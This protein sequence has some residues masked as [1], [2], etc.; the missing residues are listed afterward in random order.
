MTYSTSD[1]EQSAKNQNLAQGSFDLVVALF[2]TSPD[3]ICDPEPTLTHIRHT[4]RPGGYLVMLILPDGLATRG[5]ADAFNGGVEDWDN[6]LRKTGFSGLDT[7]TATATHQSQPGA[8][9][10]ATLLATQAED[11]RVSFLRE[12]LPAAK[13][14]LSLESLTILGEDR[15][16]DVSQKLGRSVGA[17]YTKVQIVTSLSG[18]PDIPSGGTVVCFL[19]LQPAGSEGGA[20]T[21]PVLGIVQT[22][23]RRAHNILW[24]TSGARSGANPHGNMIK[25]LLRSVALEMPDIRTQFLDFATSDDV[26]ADIIAKML[27]QVEAYSVLEVEDRVKDGD[28]L[29]YRE[30]EVFVDMN[31]QCFVPRLRLNAVQNRRYNSG[32]RLLTHSV[33]IEDTDVSITQSGSVVVGNLTRAIHAAPEAAGRFTKVRLCHSLLKSIKITD[34]SSA[35]FSLGRVA[36]G[37]IDGLVLLM[38]TSLSSVV[39]APSNLIWPAPF[40]NPDSPEQA[41]EALTALSAHILALSILET[42]T[43]GKPLVVL[44]PGHALGRALIALAPTHSVQLHLLTTTS[45]TRTEE[46][47]LPW[48]FIAPQDPIRSLQRKL[49]WQTVSTFL[50]L[51]TSE[52]G[53]R[54]AS[55]IIRDCLPLGSTQKLDR[56]DFVGGDVQL[57]IDDQTSMQQ[58]TARVVQA[59]SSYCP[60]SATDTAS[61]TSFPRLGLNDDGLA[62][63]KDQAIISWEA[64][65]MVNVREK[66]ASDRV[67]FAPDKTYWLVGLTRGLGLS[68][69]EWMVERGARNIVLSSRRP[70]VEHAW[71]AEMASRGCT[72]KVLARL[73]QPSLAIL[74]RFGSKS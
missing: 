33:S 48:K 36:D 51:S 11:D 16:R 57:D 54:C 39:F 1:A 17:H 69:C 6:L 63:Q 20:L 22:M 10:F 72:V 64:G 3:A 44:D 52:A 41:A 30:P 73:V 24:V 53:S 14:P 19:G 61:I 70:E 5:K 28:M 35:Y 15:D 21:A 45:A 58:V 27:L 38:S 40:I 62:G 60:A 25:G 47:E 7:D 71:L 18:E 42:A 46:Y 23:F 9:T 55:R 49:P 8:A 26:S 68:L 2:L 29:W 13:G 34:T 59:G 31:G 37:S 4:L 12:P 32:R 66:P 65:K 50:D 67:S 56:S 43:R 74:T